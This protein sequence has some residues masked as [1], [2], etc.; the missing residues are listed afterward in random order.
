MMDDT[1]DKIA[2]SVDTSTAELSNLLVFESGTWVYSETSGGPVQISTRGCFTR[3]A[4]EKDL[5]NISQGKMDV[6]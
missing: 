1:K 2:D 4:T 5:I 3:Q 6:F